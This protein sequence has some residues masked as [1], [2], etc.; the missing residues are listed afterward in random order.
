MMKII[1]I[2]E[3]GKSLEDAL[4]KAGQKLQASVEDLDYEIIE[5]GTRGFLG[6]GHRPT[7]I[8][9]IFDTSSPLMKS[10]KALLEGILQRMGISEFSVV[11]ERQDDQILLNVETPDSGFIIG[12]KGETI[13]SIQHLITRIVNKGKDDKVYFCVDTAD[14]RARRQEALEDQALRLAEKVRDTGKPMRTSLLNPHDRRIIHL[15]LQNGHNVIT[16]SRGNDFL[17]RV[18]IK[19]KSASRRNKRKK[20]RN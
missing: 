9:V 7:R 18:E 16:V 19:P 14:Y 15:L 6:M 13:N 1:E 12:R 8:K 3:E 17:K 5:E 20:K 4:D 11:A 2:E 10:A